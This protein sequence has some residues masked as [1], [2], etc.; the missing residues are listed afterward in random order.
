MY[1]HFDA[2]LINYTC[3]PQSIYLK[4][5]GLYLLH[6]AGLFTE[7]YLFYSSGYCNWQNVHQIYAI[8]L[9]FLLIVLPLL[10]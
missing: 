10:Q 8:G 4:F 2:V 3:N 6:P 5:I 1:I 7:N 9:P